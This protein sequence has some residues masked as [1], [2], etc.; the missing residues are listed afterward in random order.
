MPPMYH[1]SHSQ[2][3]GSDATFGRFGGCPQA[4][5]HAVP[6]FYARKSR[7]VAGCP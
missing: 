5:P 7:M 3:K 1:V 4:Y 2:R 6:T